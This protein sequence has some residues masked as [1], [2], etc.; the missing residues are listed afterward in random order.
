MKRLALALLFAFTVS[1]QSTAPPPLQFPDI[2]A[3][4]T[5]ASVA[6]V[7]YKA[8][9]ESTLQTHDTNI[10]NL[11]QAQASQATQIQAL[12]TQIA[13]LQGQ[14]EA[15]QN[16]T[17]PPPPQQVTLDLTTCP[18]GPLVQTQCGLGWNLGQWTATAQGIQPAVQ[19]A[20]RSFILPAGRTLVSVKFMCMTFSN[21]QV[22]FTDSSGDNILG[23]SGTPGTATQ[24]GTSWVPASGSVTVSSVNFGAPDLRLLAVTYQ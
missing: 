17:P 21:C 2:I 5:N 6:L 22:R 16:P 3:A 24:V 23:I 19:G 8:Y 13:Q 10:W 4:Q 12:Q 1:A 20:A 14:I 9:V 18:P 11:Q 15:L 7:S